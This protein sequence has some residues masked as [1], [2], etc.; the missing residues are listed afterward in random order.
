MGESPRRL[1]VSRTV[2]Y[3]PLTETDRREMLEAIGVDD[4][5]VLIQAVPRS[6]RAKGLDVPEGLS[7]WELGREI[8]AAAGKNLNARKTLS[9][10]G[11]GSY[12]HFIPAALPQLVG[13]S[14][15]YT[16]YTPYQ[17]EA[18]QGT[19]QAIFEYQSLIAELTG[20][21]V[22]NASHYDGATSLAEAGLA[23]LRHTGRKKLLIARS[24]HPHSRAVLKTYT[25]SA[26]F[27]V[28]EFGFTAGGRYN[29][30]ELSERL[31]NEV[32]GVILQ[33]PNFFGVAEDLEG[34]AEK[35]HALGAL[36]MIAANPLSLGVLKPP[37]EWGADLAVG[38][39]QVLG[40]PANFGGPYL[41]FFAATKELVRRVPGRLAGMTLDRQGKRAFVL[42][43]QAREQHIRRERAASNICTNEG[44][45]ALAA[46]IYLTLIGKEGIRQVGELNL[47]RANYLRQK[48][49]GLKNFK[50]DLSVP[51]FNE[52]V[53]TASKP[54][55]E[56]E[57]TLLG[58]GL[59][60]GIGLEKFYPE[61]KS[62]FLVCATETKS[63]EDLDRLVEGLR[64]C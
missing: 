34:L 55:S 57:S 6:C 63:R 52:F 9:F 22:S 35:I 20:L 24:V 44:L 17:P 4:F 51:I 59:L 29:A 10:L 18:S 60:P 12:D 53:V 43:L 7:E 49:A 58:E 45:C 47:D 13:R 14:E 3:H 23:A 64:R 62:S 50:V 30:A 40:I 19:L 8:E 21:P 16:A 56:I 5:E 27:I 54:F 32:A 37:G 46:C 26:D 11:G 42:T 28:E 25:E 38:E 48:I 41:G 2:H 31:T 39:G 36:L 33:T 15:F 1:P 61:L